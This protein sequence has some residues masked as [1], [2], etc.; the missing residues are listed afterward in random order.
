MLPMNVSKFLSGSSLRAQ[1]PICDTGRRLS[2]PTITVSGQDV[3]GFGT[4]ATGNT[5]S[6]QMNQDSSCFKN[7]VIFCGW[8][9]EALMSVCR[10]QIVM[11]SICY[12]RGWCSPQWQ[13]WSCKSWLRWTASCRLIMLCYTQPEPLGISWRTRTSEVRDWPSKCPNMNPIE[14]LCSQMV[15]HIP[16]MD[17]RATMAAQLRV[18]VQQAWYVLRP[19]GLRTLVQSRVKSLLSLCLL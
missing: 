16:D 18:A 13:H 3:T 7:M 10:K 14:P 11:S 8:V 2:M 4:T 1:P 15:V 6:S 12:R 17:N 5:V 9:R 19:V